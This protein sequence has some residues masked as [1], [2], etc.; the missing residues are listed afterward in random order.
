MDTG[1]EFYLMEDK[2]LL[3]KYDYETA[4]SKGKLE[5]VYVHI[6]LFHLIEYIEV[7]I[8]LPL[9]KYKILL[10]STPRFPSLL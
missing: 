7:D 8:I 1:D 2:K 6:T 3:C 10:G 9:S 5:N 4:K